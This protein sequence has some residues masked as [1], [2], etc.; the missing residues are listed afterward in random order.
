[1][2][3]ARKRLL[4]LFGNWKMTFRQQDYSL[5]C[6]SS[7]LSFAPATLIGCCVLPCR[8]GSVTRSHKATSA[9][10]VAES[11]RE[12]IHNLWTISESN[13]RKIWNQSHSL[14]ISVFW[15][16][17]VPMSHSKNNDR[18]TSPQ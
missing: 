1:M 6:V 9:N 14:G 3:T 18:E 2:I 5:P 11:Q 4:P 17:S 7:V 8:H 16:S 10:F 15:A 13:D 12:I